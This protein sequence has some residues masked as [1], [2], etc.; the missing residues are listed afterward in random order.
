MADGWRLFEGVAQVVTALADEAPLA[1]L[2][3][4]L[5]WCDAD[6]C[7]LLHTLIR[8]LDG[9]RVLWCL[10]YSPGSVERDA[11]ASR[12]VRALRAFPATEAIALRPLTETEVRELLHGLGQLAQSDSGR[13]LAARVHEVTTGVPFYVIEL[14][15]TLFAQGWLAVDPDNGQ[16]IVQGKD[17]SAMLAFTS[18][19][20]VHE[21]IAERIECLPEELS[22]VLITIVLSTQ[23]CRADVLSHVHG[24]SRLRAAVAGDALVERHLAVEED[25]IYRCAHP[26]IAR[27]VSDTLGTTRRREVHRGLALAL[28]VVAATAGAVAD[29]V[30]VAR[31]AEL[32]GERAIAYRYAMLAAAAAEERFAYD[33]ALRWLD[34]AA[35]TAS[36]TVDANA[37]NQTTARVMASAAVQETGMA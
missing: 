36:G 29:P 25:G 9:T 18:A 12:L 31:H 17:E 28:E 26:V 8:K 21:A 24:F 16:W 20:G 30:E 34:F 33:E 22:A 1:V 14:L 15:K 27:V 4:D 3:D 32:G 23:G 7:T 5:Q 11:P 19:P 10:T 6:S 37:V 13:R 35:G 2:I